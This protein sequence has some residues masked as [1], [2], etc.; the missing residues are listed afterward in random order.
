MALLLR[1]A[2]VVIFAPTIPLRVSDVASIS[3]TMY[4]ST[5]RHARFTHDG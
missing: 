4:S 2:K 5:M 3:H 1:F